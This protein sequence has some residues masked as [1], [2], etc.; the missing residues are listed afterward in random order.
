MST[1]IV[2]LVILFAMPLVV[3]LFELVG[4]L[5]RVPE[6]FE[7]KPTPAEKAAEVARVER[8][9]ASFD[10]IQEQMV[11]DE[12]ARWAAENWAQQMSYLSE[13]EQEAVREAQASSTRARL[14]GEELMAQIEAARRDPAFGVPEEES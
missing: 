7:K 2:V 4:L 5:L 3:L 11:Q 8:N 13:E 10:T 1:V 6:V 9:A 14:R 12:H